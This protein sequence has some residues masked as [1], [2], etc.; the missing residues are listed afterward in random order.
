MKPLGAGA[1]VGGVVIFFVAC[2]N[3]EAAIVMKMGTMDRLKTLFAA[4]IT[5]TL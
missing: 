2:A 5:A 4:P 3:M 1:L